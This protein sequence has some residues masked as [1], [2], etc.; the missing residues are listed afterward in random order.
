VAAVATGAVLVIGGGGVLVA[1]VAAAQNTAQNAA[2]K[3]AAAKNTA[4]AH[5]GPGVAAGVPRAGRP[6]GPVFAGH[7]PPAAAGGPGRLQLV[8]GSGLVHGM[9]TEYPRSRAG[10]V[11]AA[12]QFITELGS[13]LAPDRAAAVARVAADSSYP[14]APQDAAA[15]TVDTRRKLGLG[16]AGPLPPGTAV[17][18]V[19]VMYQLR[20]VTADRLTVVLLF[21]YTETTTAGI[22]EHLGVTAT[23]L[24]W[25]PASWRLLKPSGADLTSAQLSD[26]LATPGTAAATAKGWEA[27]TDAL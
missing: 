22:R 15:G 16:A 3:N 12:V 19:P 5:A 4:A 10:A 13:T 14:T 6:A 8:T 23:R 7:A 24:T 20:D 26:L 2:A 9:Y 11:S 21:D 27:L 18:L 17:L 1:H 25:T